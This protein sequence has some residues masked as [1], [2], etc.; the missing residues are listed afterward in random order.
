MRIVI[1]GGTGVLGQRIVPSLLGLGHQ[2]TILARRPERARPLAVLGAEVAAGD[3]FDADRVRQVVAAA[4]PEVVMHQ[5]TDLAGGVGP[6]NA[7][8]RRVGT[9]NLVDAALAVGARRF[10]VQSI[11]WAYEGGGEPA[12]EATPLDTG[13]A[14]AARRDTVAAVGVMEQAA[15]ELPEAVILR[16]GLLYGPGTWYWAGGVV[17]QTAMTGQL[18]SSGDVAS[19]VHA[20]DA[21]A[22]AVAALDWPPGAVNIVDDEPAAARVWVPVFCAAVGAPAPAAP[23]ARYTASAQDIAAE[24]AWYARGAS[25]QYARRELGWKPAWPSWRDGFAELAHGQLHDR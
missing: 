4:A 5:L 24:R 12:D 9:R 17:A 23:P 1:A 7:E 3:V 10:I 22:A 20:D 2:V 16:N 21:A 8:V 13:A 15:R 6:G 19:F 11:A 25:N 14:D 18:R